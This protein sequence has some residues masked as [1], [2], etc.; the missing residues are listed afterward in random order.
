MKKLFLSL[1]IIVASIVASYGVVLPVLAAPATPSN[2]ELACKGSGGVW[3]GTKCGP[4]NGSVSLFEGP[5]A[6][7]PR[8]IS[9]LLF[10]V[11][12]I[13]VIMVIIGGIRYVLSNGDQNAVT[14]AKNT[15]LYAVIG[16]I[17][18]ILAYALVQF[19]ISSL[20]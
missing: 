12:G 14:A 11:G 8:I 2:A 15:I 10:L 6:L 17:V 18:A 5:N 19:I 16:L 1:T 4:A 3:D 7:I 20:A 9:T 13:A